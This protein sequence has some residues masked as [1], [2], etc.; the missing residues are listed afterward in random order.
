[1]AKYKGTK[2]QTTVYKTIHRKLKI[3]Q[4]K[5]TK[6]QG[7]LRYSGRV[8]SSCTCGMYVLYAFKTL[9]FSFTFIVQD[10]NI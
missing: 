6:T 2:R 4:H 9:T 5:P 10:I 7:D 3:E 1:M 8:D